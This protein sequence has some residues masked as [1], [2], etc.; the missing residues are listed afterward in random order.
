MLHLFSGYGIDEA[1]V[2]ISGEHM[3]PPT[4]PLRIQLE[5]SESSKS[6]NSG[7]PLGLLIKQKC[8][9]NDYI[10]MEG[11]D[12]HV[13]RIMIGPRVGWAH[14]ACGQVQRFVNECV[15]QT[16]EAAATSRGGTREL[17][18]VS[19]LGMRSSEQS[20]CALTLRMYSAKKGQRT[21][22]NTGRHKHPIQV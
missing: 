19:D 2:P 8:G 5:D 20:T 18:H 4:R 13:E 22:D 10:T 1:R 14:E 16:Q 6:T 12:E 9:W 7:I 15:I 17:R 11:I 3:P 21:S